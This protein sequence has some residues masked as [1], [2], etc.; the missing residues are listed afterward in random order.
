[1]KRPN[2]RA[3]A[4]P[5]VSWCASVHTRPLVRQ[6]WLW[7]M[8]RLAAALLLAA[9]PH[10]HAFVASP[11][12]WHGAD[13]SRAHAR[14]VVDARLADAPPEAPVGHALETCKLACDS[15]AVLVSEIYAMVGGSAG[16]G[17]ARPGVAF[18]GDKSYFTLADGARC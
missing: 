13:A 3:A 10:H 8:L 14:R 12:R 9:L 15:I 2:P 7:D 16:Q 1:M 18:K 11:P 4:K 5:L 6:T 17:S